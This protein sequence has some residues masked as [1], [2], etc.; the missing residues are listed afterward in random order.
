[1]TEPSNLNASDDWLKPIFE[2][3]DDGFEPLGREGKILEAKAAI[4]QHIQEEVRKAYK[5]GY[6]RGIKVESAVRDLADE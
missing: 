3:L 1:M 5:K 2:K 4:K 6:A